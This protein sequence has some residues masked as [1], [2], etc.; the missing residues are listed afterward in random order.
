MPVTSSLGLSAF[1]ESKKDAT[2][3][4]ISDS[5][6][7]MYGPVK[8]PDDSTI[9]V[10]LPFPHFNSTNAYLPNLINVGHTYR[11]MLISTTLNGRIKYI[12][13]PVSTSYTASVTTQYRTI[14]VGAGSA[15]GSGT[16][17]L[18][19]FD[20]SGN[21]NVL[22]ST[23]FYHSTGSTFL[24][25]IAI[26]E[27]NG[28]W[29]TVT[30]QTT[31]ENATDKVGVFGKVN[32]VPVFFDFLPGAG[33][34]NFGNV[35]LTFS[36]LSEITCA[37]EVIESGIKYYYIAGRDSD[38][39]KNLVV[40]KID[41]STIT[42]TVV[43]KKKY[44]AY[45]AETGGTGNRW[46][47]APVAIRYDKHVG[48]IL[49]LANYVDTS[50]FSFND[51]TIPNGNNTNLNS[52]AVLFALDPSTGNNISSV[53]SFFHP[54]QK[55]AWATGISI[56]DPHPSATNS[57]SYLYDAPYF[58]SMVTSVSDV[59]QTEYPGSQTPSYICSLSKGYLLD[60]ISAG[61]PAYG[62]KL[63]SSKNPGGGAPTR[64][65]FARLDGYTSASTV[66]MKEPDVSATYTAYNV[67]GQA[68]INSG[69]DDNSLSITPAYFSLQL[70]AGLSSNNT[71]YT[72]GS[73]FT[74]TSKDEKSTELTLFT[75][76]LTAV[77]YDTVHPY[78]QTTTYATAP[79][80]SI[81]NLTQTSATYTQDSNISNYIGTISRHTI[82]LGDATYSSSL[83]ALPTYLER[84]IYSVW[85][86]ITDEINYVVTDPQ[87]GKVQTIPNV[88]LI[89]LTD[90]T[91]RTI[92][93]RPI[94]KKAAFSTI[95]NAFYS[96]TA[97]WTGQYTWSNTSG[98]Q[99]ITTF[100]TY[101]DSDILFVTK[102]YEIDPTYGDIAQGNYNTADFAAP[103]SPPSSFS[104]NVFVEKG[105]SSSI[106]SGVS[107]VRNHAN[108]IPGDPDFGG[109]QNIP[110]IATV[111]GNNQVSI[112]TP[113]DMNDIIII[114]R[115]SSTYPVSG[116]GINAGK[117]YP[118]I[119]ADT[120]IVIGRN[121][122]IDSQVLLS[123]ST[124][125]DTLINAS[126]GRGKVSFTGS[127]GSDKFVV[128]GAIGYK[129]GYQFTTI[130]DL[131]SGAG[132][133]IDLSLVFNSDGTR[134]SSISNFSTSYQSGNYTIILTGKYLS[135]DGTFA[136]STRIWGGSILIASVTQ[137]NALASLQFNQGTTLSS[138]LG[139]TVYNRLVSESA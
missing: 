63:V 22:S 84:L 133:R 99:T 40:Y 91:F 46:T 7:K 80:T 31:Y 79:S 86:P 8:Y 102:Y 25:G 103:Y 15:L 65:I 58:I 128:A 64:G 27:R 93:I 89:T 73:S 30:S 72:Y 110:Q 3:S 5:W 21:G 52:G 114:S 96:N 129:Y 115:D 23:I 70:E 121:E 112:Y 41:S 43:W 11:G 94:G 122:D 100:P 4:A 82:D 109:S 137:S 74:Y 124:G 16:A 68:I 127:G 108:Y 28:A 69:A 101:T 45:S 131:S 111:Y 138:L 88:G 12:N 90:S 42:P 119:G 9:P 92:K 95:D 34:P 134:V 59:N 19:M 97:G 50:L 117:A 116:T 18:D 66:S 130:N 14:A 120:A 105:L 35:T 78:C 32:N 10:I 135:I 2:E 33:T 20:A 36:S 113:G 53:P 77:T 55:A 13:K 83:K 39:L 51:T 87:T 81:S 125:N 123:T 107:V 71:K 132:D 118:G 104:W 17:K 56:G 1:S 106:L 54:Y 139:S 47:Y 85:N 6:F 49:V 38:S 37:C 61:G 48:K 75:Q 29:N 44:A 26:P 76:E 62:I 98:L 24:S 57:T 136:N 60:G 126:I 67:R